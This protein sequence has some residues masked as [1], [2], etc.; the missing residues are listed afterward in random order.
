MAGIP[1]T[2][3]YV[4]YWADMNGFHEW[5]VVIDPKKLDILPGQLEAKNA[6]K[7]FRRTYSMNEIPLA[8]ENEYIPPFFSDP[9]NRDVTNKYQTTSDVTIKA[10][11]T[12]H[13]VNHA[14]LAI[15][16]DRQLRV[17]DWGKVQRNKVTFHDLGRNI[18][19]FPVYYDN[20]NQKNFSY[21][22][23]LHANGTTTSLHPDKKNL[24][25]DK[26][27]PEVPATR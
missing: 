12:D 24:A 9:F 8:E 6:P 18:I 27:Y 4:P 1:A 22:L 23:I 10:D 15:F 2:T 11:I 17:V 13:P 5:T 25:D 7:V 14:Y 3:D 20:D 21:P 26:T 19:Y 16:N